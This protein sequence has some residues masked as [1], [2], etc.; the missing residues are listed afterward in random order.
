MRS[1][2]WGPSEVIGRI[3]L[4]ISDGSQHCH[5]NYDHVACWQVVD[6]QVRLIEI[7]YAGSRKD[8]PYD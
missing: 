8:A 7:Y 5:L 6:K 1:V 4:N 3:I 2:N